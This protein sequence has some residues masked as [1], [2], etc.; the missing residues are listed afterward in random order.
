MFLYGPLCS[1]ELKYPFIAM[2]F[3]FVYLYDFQVCDLIG[4]KIHFHVR[5]SLHSFQLSADCY[6]IQGRSPVVSVSLV[7][8]P[9]AML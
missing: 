2:P 6:G 4:K 5:C 3:E 1:R 9:Q 7:A 8:S